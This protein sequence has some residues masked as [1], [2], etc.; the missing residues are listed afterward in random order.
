MV[1]LGRIRPVDDLLSRFRAGPSET[2][3]ASVRIAATVRVSSN[4][5]LLI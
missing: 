4:Q 2:D 5:S 1:G 3:P